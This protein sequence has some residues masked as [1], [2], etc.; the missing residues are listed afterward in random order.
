VSVRWI[1]SRSFTLNETIVAL[2]VVPGNRLL[3]TTKRSD[4]S[5]WDC[6]RG[7]RTDLGTLPGGM[8]A[9]VRRVCSLGEGRIAALHREPQGS[10]VQ[11]SVRGRG[12]R[13]AKAAAGAGA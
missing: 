3:V 6:A 7:G 1:G 4:L 8:G 5:L 12:G 13:G 9:P 11:A 10:A 2:T